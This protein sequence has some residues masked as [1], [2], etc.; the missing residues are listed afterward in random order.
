MIDEYL[1][2]LHEAYLISDKTISINIDKFISGESNKLLIAGLSGSGKSTLCRYLS[3]KYN[4]ECF[5]TDYCGRKINHKYR[6]F[7]AENPPINMLKELFHA[8]YF[9][10]V[11]P[12]MKNNKRQVVEGG[13]FWQSYLFFPKIRKELNRHPIIIF[14]SSALKASWG[15]FKRSK[16]KHDFLYATKKISIIYARNFKMLDKQI[17]SF[18]KLRL[19]AGGKVEEF[20]VP[21]L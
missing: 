7:G 8:A 20:K 3:K 12:G 19:R 17:A 21:K 6:N 11:S 2:F 13:I 9:K 16:T 4:A 15:A 18:R 14:G 1:D 5:E 10:C